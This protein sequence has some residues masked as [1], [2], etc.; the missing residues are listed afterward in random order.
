MFSFSSVCCEEECLRFLIFRLKVAIIYGDLQKN[1]QT[2]CKLNW[3]I[4]QQKTWEHLSNNAALL[5]NHLNTSPGSWDARGLCPPHSQ[6]HQNPWLDFLGLIIWVEIRGLSAGFGRVY[7][8]KQ[9]GPAAETGML[10]LLHQMK[11]SCTGIH[12]FLHFFALGLWETA[13]AA[14]I[15]CLDGKHPS[16]PRCPSFALLVCAHSGARLIVWK[17]QRFVSPKQNL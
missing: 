12:I 10:A 2:L 16:S 14:G 1:N 5:A 3:S 7:R 4:R 13:R 17:V 15:H 11:I 9:H 6:E 8:V